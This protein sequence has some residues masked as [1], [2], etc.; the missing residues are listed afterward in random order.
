MERGIS[1]AFVASVATLF[2]S[3]GCM[4]KSR[5]GAPPASSAMAAPV[6]DLTGAIQVGSQHPEAQEPK[7][8]F[9]VGV[10]G[11]R[12]RVVEGEAAAVPGTFQ[13][14]AIS[15]AVEPQ[16]TFTYAGMRFDYPRNFTFEAD[17]EGASSSWTL[18]GNDLKIMVFR[19]DER[20]ST[21]DYV[22]ELVKRFGPTTTTAPMQLRLG[23]VDY[24]GTRLDVRLVQTDLIYQV[25]G[26]PRYEGKDR[27]IAIQDNK[28]AA[29]VPEGVNARALLTRTFHVDD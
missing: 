26:L 25:V 2:L 18:S 21:E 11:T 5:S 15:I 8:S 23:G 10:A 12:V 14:P 16:R 13:N 1:A 17:L 6:A 20:V 28:K 22:K 3:I 9:N 7:L 19:F 24:P 27:I 29:N 4:S